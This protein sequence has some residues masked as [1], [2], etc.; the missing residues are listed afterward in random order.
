MPPPLFLDISTDDIEESATLVDGKCVICHNDTAEFI[1][2][3][4]ESKGFSSTPSS[5]YLSKYENHTM[6]LHTVHIGNIPRARLTSFARIC[7]NTQTRGILW[8][9]KRNALRIQSEINTMSGGLCEVKTISS[10]AKEFCSKDYPCRL[11]PYVRS[12]IVSIAERECIGNFRR[13]ASAVNILRLIALHRY[14]GLYFDSN[15]VLDDVQQ[16]HQIHQ[17]DWSDVLNGRAGFKVLEATHK[18]PYENVCAQKSLY[19]DQAVTPRMQPYVNQIECSVIFSR[20][21]HLFLELS[22]FGFYHDYYL[23]HQQTGVS[24]HKTHFELSELGRRALMAKNK[25]T[26]DPCIIN[27]MAVAIYVLSLRFDLQREEF[28][29][30]YKTDLRDQAL[31][32][33]QHYRCLIDS[34][35]YKSPAVFS[36]SGIRFVKFYSHSH[37]KFGELGAQYD[38]ALSMNP[39]NE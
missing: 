9:D 20:A 35:G 38:D 7:R 2:H 29:M 23:Q 5:D 16:K 36:F 12:L 31:Q 32:Y 15:V 34:Q 22:L 14:G 11:T 25:Q 28:T 10:L 3:R 1:C 24:I 30:D 33:Q 17:H 8:T 27:S 39:F 13:I 26:R 6:F 19:K 18:W 4:C 21:R 37:K